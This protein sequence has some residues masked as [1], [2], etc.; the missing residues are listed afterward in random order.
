[1][2]LMIMRKSQLLTN[3]Y[4]ETK[5]LMKWHLGMQ[6]KMYKPSIDVDEAQEASPGF[7]SNPNITG[8]M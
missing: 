1:M 4:L 7:T 6:V 5:G 2:I 8:G 3:Y